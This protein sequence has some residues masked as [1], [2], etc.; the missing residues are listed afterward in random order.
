MISNNDPTNDFRGRSGLSQFLG[1]WGESS[2]TPPLTASLVLYTSC[3]AAAYAK[4]HVAHLPVFLC[5]SLTLVIIGELIF[6]APVAIASILNVTK[7]FNFI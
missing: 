3:S 7:L 2:I 6:M 1:K 5:C 4:M